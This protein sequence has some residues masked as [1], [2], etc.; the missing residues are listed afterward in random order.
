MTTLFADVYDPNTKLV[1]GRV[2]ATT[3]IDPTSGASYIVPLGY[4]PQKTVNYFSTLQRS[5]AS[6]LISNSS[7]VVGPLYT[8]T[9]AIANFLNYYPGFQFDLQRGFNDVSYGGFVPAFTPIASFDFGL[10]TSSFGLPLSATELGGGI[11]NLIQASTNPNIDTTGTLWNNPVN[12]PNIENGYNYRPALVFSAA[13]TGLAYISGAGAT[14]TGFVLSGNDGAN[15][16]CTIHAPTGTIEVGKANLYVDL[17]NGGNSVRFTGIGVDTFVYA[18]NNNIDFSGGQIATVLGDGNKIQVSQGSSVSSVGTNTFDCTVNGFTFSETLANINANVDDLGNAIFTSSVPGNTSTMT[19]DTEG[20]G[21][22]LYNRNLIDFAPN[23]VNSISYANGS[24][25]FGLAPVAESVMQGLTWD[26]TSGQAQVTM[27]AGGSQ[28]QESLDTT[29]PF[30]S[31]RVDGTSVTQTRTWGYDQGANTKIIVGADRISKYSFDQNGELVSGN[32][33]ITDGSYAT[34]GTD[35]DGNTVQTTYNQDNRVVAKAVIDANGSLERSY[36][37]PLTGAWLYTGQFDSQG[38]LLTQYAIRTLSFSQYSAI[39]ADTVAG[40]IIAKFLLNHN[41]PASLA[42]QSFV[43]SSFNYLQNVNASTTSFASDFAMNLTSMAGGILGSNLGAELFE[44]LGLPSQLGALTGSALAQATAQELTSFVAQEILGFEVAETGGIAVAEMSLTQF[45]SS[46][47]NSFVSAGAG[48]AGSEFAQLICPNNSETTQIANAVGTAIGA[49]IGGPIGSFLGSFLGSLTGDLITAVF[50]G[51]PRGDAYA[52]SVIEYVPGTGFKV[53]YTGIDNN[54]DPAPA[55]QMGAVT[56]DIANKILAAVGGTATY[57]SHWYVGYKGDQYLSFPIDGANYYTWFNDPNGAVQHALMRMM[58]NTTITGGNPYMEYVFY[59][60]RN[61]SYETLVNDLNIAQDFSYFAIDPGSFN[62]ALAAANDPARLQTWQTEYDTAIS[63]GHDKLGGLQSVT[64][65]ANGTLLMS[66]IQAANALAVLAMPLVS[67]VAVSD[68]VDN[69]SANLASLN[70]LKSAGKV[71]SISVEDT[72]AGISLRFDDLQAIATQTP[73]SVVLTDGGTPELSLSDWQ[74]SNDTAAL[75]AIT[76]PYRIRVYDVGCWDVAGLAQQANI[77]AIAVHDAV[78]SIVGYSSS[79]LAAKS[80]GKMISV[81][82]QGPAQELLSNLDQVKSLIANGV[83]VAFEMMPTAE[84]MLDMSAEGATVVDQA[85]AFIPDLDSYSLAITDTASEVLKYL[86]TLQTFAAKWRLSS[87]TLIDDTPP[88]LA[89]SAEQA[90]NNSKALNMITSPCAITVSDTA[91]NIEAHLDALQTLASGGKLTSINFSDTGTPSMTITTTQ[92]AD[93][94]TALGLLTGD[95]NLTTVD[96]SNE[97]VSTLQH[98]ANG[99]SIRTVFDT[100][101]GLATAYTLDGPP[102]LSV[103]AAVGT[104]VF[105]QGNGSGG[106]TDLVNI[107]GG[108]VHIASDGSADV[109]GGANFINVNGGGLVAYG[110]DNNTIQL[111]AGSWAVVFGGNEHSIT[112]TDCW[113]EIAGGAEDTVTVG[114]TNSGVQISG[115][116]GHTINASSGTTI[117]TSVSGGWEDASFMNLSQ[118]TVVVGD[119]ANA[120]VTGDGNTIS[121]GIFSGLCVNGDTNI[122]TVSDNSWASISGDGNILTAGA[123]CWIGLDNG[124]NSTVTLGSDSA[125]AIYYGGGHTINAADGNSIDVSGNGV[126]GIAD[127]INMSYGT[128]LIQSDANVT[129]SGNGNTITT[130]A[131]DTL[132]ISSGSHTIIDGAGNAV[133]T[134]SGAGANIYQFGSNFGQDSIDNSA[135]TAAH[136]EVDF[137]A[138]TDQQLWFARSGDDLDVILLG[139]SSEL[140]VTDW[141]DGLENQV[142]SFQANGLSLDG[143]LAQLVSAMATYSTNNPG[144]DPSAATSMPTDSTLQTT[145]ASAWHA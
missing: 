74:Y 56:V 141:Y 108:A 128:V 135:G 120:G 36:Y 23:T 17:S 55:Q 11:V 19:I 47:A 112:G 46:F 32:V 130:N 104:T 48:L 95:Y 75:S 10:A 1:I 68:T 144:F 100:A 44:S 145:I 131:N 107:S 80:A 134:N 109:N 102:T 25:D 43:H 138:A 9:V 57:S 93:D 97:V 98:S 115:G 90:G 129:I 139:T 60:D 6:E 70:T 65:Q 61:G 116:S 4:D 24:F 42:A 101:T 123:S 28:F 118:G 73:I 142:Q 133:Y 140:T 20:N 96:T 13:E 136:G 89:L 22:F 29:E 77:A 50:G 21:S 124:N 52:A 39:V 33:R 88:T 62:V 92:V 132:T 87:I 5:I 78:G 81:T 82:A 106:P 49:I 117:W 103:T 8:A 34:I 127:T 16:V 35:S 84:P 71:T 126:T 64:R 143:G 31:M 59:V 45:A 110:G 105:V 137:T 85:R 83:Q 51:G 54:G 66:G 111:G 30:T 27:S 7:A 63:K 41:L 67:A 15:A 26:P 99:S 114:G 122:I 79:L 119:G 69:I 53:T 91:E 94:A 113:L 76:S 18:K 125:V 3:W 86:D 37:D 72:A 14:D 2:P 12:V 58:Q 40:Q 38:H 121:E